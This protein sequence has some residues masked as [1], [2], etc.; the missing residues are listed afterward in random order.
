MSN[1][2]IPVLVFLETSECHF[3]A[4]DVLDEVNK[5]LHLENQDKYLFGV[6]QVFEESFLVPS[7]ALADVGCSVRVILSLTGFTTK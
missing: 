2:V 5:M 1:E 7:D 3:C 4:R 6:F